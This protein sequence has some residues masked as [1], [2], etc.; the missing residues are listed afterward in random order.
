MT[1]DKNSLLQTLIQDLVKQPEKFPLPINEEDE[2]YLFSLENLNGDRD[3][4]AV[5][6]YSLG[7]QI[8][9]SVRQIVEWHFQGFDRVGSFL[10]FA[11]GYGRFTRFLLQELN[12]QQV[13]VSDIYADAVKFQTAEFGVN[14]IVSTEYPQDYQC[15]SEALP[16]KRDRSFDCMLAS[17]FFSHVP[18]F[19]FT[20]WLEKLYSLLNPQGILIFSV[21]D[22]ILLGDIE[23]PPSGILFSADSESRTLDKELYGTTY[24]SEAFVSQVIEKV[25]GKTN[26]YKRIRKGLCRFQD[27]YVLVKEPTAELPALNFS[28]HP[29]GYVDKLQFTSTG[30]LQLNGWAAD[31]NFNFGQDSRIEE[32]QIL[33]NGAI[34][35]KCMPY[36][37]RPD[38]AAHF[39]KPEIINSGWLCYLGKN[40]V[41]PDDIVLVKAINSQRLER[42]MT[43]GKLESLLK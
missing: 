5:R 8:F 9:D 25:T 34:A 24:V 27:I 15:D 32:V 2:M 29:D 28:H 30:E 36:F 40:T 14:G 26:N 16:A 22:A 41:K 11:C 37:D 13:W 33:V 38:V 10:D 39:G 17:S 19:T 21:H 43:A 1:T 3:A 31:F 20:T 23:L 4:A 42:V 7:K 12:P 35:Q 18:E 6:Y